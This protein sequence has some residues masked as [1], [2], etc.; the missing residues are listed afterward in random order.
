MFEAKSVQLQ[1][2][3]LRV[4]NNGWY[5]SRRDD[6]FSDSRSVCR[7][8]GT[9]VVPVDDY[10]GLKSGAIECRRSAAKKV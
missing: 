4:R 8:S 6:I 9:G 1:K 3:Q 7:P 5:K 2:F 10:P